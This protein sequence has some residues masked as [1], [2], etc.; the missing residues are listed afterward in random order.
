MLFAIVTIQASPAVLGKDCRRLGM[1]VM[2]CRAIEPPTPLALKTGAEFQ[3]DRS[4]PRKPGVR[5]QQ[6]LW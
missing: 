4:K 2:A 6:L 1:G 3:A 5:R